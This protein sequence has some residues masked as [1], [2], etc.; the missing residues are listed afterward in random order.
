MCKDIL[1][2]LIRRMLL[3]CHYYM[4]CLQ[5]QDNLNQQHPNFISHKDKTILKFVWN[6]EKSGVVK[7]ILRKNKFRVITLPDFKIY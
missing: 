5:S 7:A 1:C 6:H 3:K 4:K 2:S